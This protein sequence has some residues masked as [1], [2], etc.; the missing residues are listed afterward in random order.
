MSAFAFSKRND[1]QDFFALLLGILSPLWLFLIEERATGT[2]QAATPEAEPAKPVAIPAPSEPGHDADDD[3]AEIE[4]VPVTFDETEEAGDERRRREWD[5]CEAEN[6]QADE[7]TICGP[8]FYRKG[9]GKAVRY[10][11]A[12]MGGRHIPDGPRFRRVKKG[13]RWAYLPV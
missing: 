7:A 6:L 9:E 5:R 2:K 13:K 8:L 3:T 12:D 4:V 10:E 1:L 11:P